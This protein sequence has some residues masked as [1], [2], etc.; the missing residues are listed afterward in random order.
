MAEGVTA[1]NAV[2]MGVMAPEAAEEG[3]PTVL[4]NREQGGLIT[5]GA[6]STST[7]SIVQQLEDL[8]QETTTST[9]ATE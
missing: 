7:S 8:I 3:G 9:A 2:A 5:E 1:I 4:I 6:I